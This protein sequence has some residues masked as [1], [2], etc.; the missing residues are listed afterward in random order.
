MLHS[1][2]KLKN[3]TQ[4]L[5]TNEAYS[6]LC[7]GLQ[8][9]SD[10]CFTPNLNQCYDK[11]DAYFH[12]VYM[13]EELKSA[14]TSLA[15][16]ILPNVTNVNIIQCPV[17]QANT[18]FQ[19]SSYYTIVSLAVVLSF[20]VLGILMV[21]GSYAIFKFRLIPRISAWIQ[22]E[23]YGD[24]NNEMTNVQNSAESNDSSNSN[25]NYND[26]ELE[27][28]RNAAE[29][30]LPNLE[31]LKGSGAVNAMANYR[32]QNEQSGQST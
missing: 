19:N 21:S 28:A 10:F 3:T 22:N 5:I 32:N 23:P 13:I 16:H 9:I 1:H 11:H 31:D 14:A 12:Y 17:F 30:P 18:P 15:M 27:D 25:T 2:S 4:A 6:K 20:L 8:Q 29:E 7:Q 24:I 26:L